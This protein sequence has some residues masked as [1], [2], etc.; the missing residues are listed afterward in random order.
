MYN[1]YTVI[2]TYYIFSSKGEAI[3]GF[4]FFFYATKK[5]D[6]KKSIFWEVKL[7]WNYIKNKEIL[8]ELSYR[9]FIYSIY[10]LKILLALTNFYYNYIINITNVKYKFI[11]SNAKERAICFDSF[12][13]LIVFTFRTSVIFKSF[14]L[15]TIS[16]ILKTVVVRSFTIKIVLVA[17]IFVFLTYLIKYIKHIL[18][19]P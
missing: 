7:L 19:R 12:F 8:I 17:S 16:A 9:H 18:H 10:T 5:T 13:F 14:I 15:S 3:R 2:S 1:G 11:S 4:S 6:Y